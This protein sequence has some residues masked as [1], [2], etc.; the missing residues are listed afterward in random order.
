[1]A[2]QVELE[3]N[4]K[5][6]DKAVKT[7]GQLERELEQAREA[8]KEVEVGSDA[9]NKLADKIQQA[10][11]EVKTLEKQME[12]LE[13]QQK[14]EAFLKLGEGIAGGF[15]MAQGSMALLGVESEN[16]EKI[17]VK[18]QAAISIAMGAR[19]M[20]E[21]ALMA[22]TAKRVALEKLA[23]L[24]TKLSTV[25]TKAATIAAKIYT[26]TLKGMGVAA[27]V[28]T[29]GMKAL[30]AAIISTGIGALVVALGTIV[31]YWDDIKGA[32]TGVSKEM[33]DQLD[34]AK[35]LKDAAIANMEANES[36]VNQLKLQGKSQKEILKLR[37]SDIEA[38]IE[39]SK[40]ELEK[41]KQAKQSAV[42][43]AAYGET[44][45]RWIFGILTAPISYVA[46][47]I[48][49][50]TRGMVA[51]GLLEE[52]MQT[53]LLS[54]WT[55]FGA[56]LFGLNEEEAQKDMD[57]EIAIAEK[58]INDLKEK[59]A[60]LQIE[61]NNINKGG[62]DS[63]KENQEQADKEALDALDKFLEEYQA[64][65]DDNLQTEEEKEINAVR[66][67]Y[68]KLIAEAEKYGLE[69]ADLKQFQEEKIAEIEEK[70]RK[71]KENKDKEASDK[72]KALDKEVADSKIAMQSKALEAGAALFEKNKK[73]S[74][75]IAVSQTLF[76]TQQAIMQA[77]TGSGTD[78]LLPYPVKV[79][80]AI[81]AGIMGAAS[82]RN[83]L[84]ENIGETAGGGGAS[85]PQPMTPSTTGAFTL[86]GS[87][88]EQEPVKAYVVTDEMSD[89][90]AQLS[91]IRR[92]STI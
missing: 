41:Q 58:G 48:D 42:D 70:Y 52:G 10:G 75:G 89:S 73:I 30:K 67:K 68:E 40:A 35:V 66:D 54:G 87:I 7:L 49:A 90:Q 71:E 84:S 43:M 2:E 21:A 45:V 13:P 38:V 77:L 9:F 32:V 79:G 25:A 62:S 34:T 16:L 64:V 88:P 55:G 51:L 5:G 76:S 8:I 4:I 18:V 65:L 11:S 22:T 59:A 81:S 39:S 47:A 27:S 1:M 83:I 80:N 26:V 20:S 57:A 91:D 37:I 44:A 78:A 19:M 31:A 29:K 50:I 63:R 33:Q 69:T 36:S 53:D 74:K 46:G 56:G 24:Q 14:T 82:I 86:G 15:A 85:T 3:L 17:Q 6:G 60:G 72:Q 12:G 28:S 23:A 61:L 92:R